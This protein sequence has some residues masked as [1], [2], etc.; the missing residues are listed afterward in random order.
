MQV[1]HLRLVEAEPAAQFEGSLVLVADEGDEL[2]KQAVIASAADQHATD[3]DA[4]QQRQQLQARL[5]R[6]KDLYAG[7]S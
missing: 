7:E 4:E 1:L 3:L 6:L 5:E 2:W